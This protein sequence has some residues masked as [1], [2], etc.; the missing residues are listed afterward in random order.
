MNTK[1]FESALELAK[2]KNFNRAAENLYITQPALTY[3]INALEE[4]VGFRIFDRSGKGAALTPAGEQFISSLRDITAQLKR[5]VE[6]GQNFAFRYRDNIRIAMSVRPALYY[7]PEIMKIFEEEEPSVSITPYFDYYHSVDS[8]LKGDQDILFA[9]RDL[10]RQVPDI[11]SFPLFDSHIY[12]VCK[13]D[14]PLS[15][16]KIIKEKDLEGRTLLIGGGSPKGLRSLQQQLIR[17]EKISYLNSEDHDTS[18]TFV[19]AGKAVVLSPGFLNDHNPEFRWIPFETK[20]VIPC[21]LCVHSSDKRRPVR[22]LVKMII[23][24]YQGKEDL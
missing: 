14:D 4:E 11:T 6:Q 8:F 2:T 7:L 24:Y 3:Q 13:K 5:A 22:D 23:G 21:V 16:K 18:I 12:L 10:I 9:V 15:D 1:Y 19:A 20:E 17:N